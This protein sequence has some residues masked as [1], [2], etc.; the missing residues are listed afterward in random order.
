MSVGAAPLCFYSLLRGLARWSD[1][2]APCEWRA[3]RHA[4]FHQETEREAVR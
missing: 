4:F 3:V 1:V 2:W